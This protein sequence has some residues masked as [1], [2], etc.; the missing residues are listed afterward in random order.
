MGWR[1]IVDLALCIQEH[2]PPGAGRGDLAIV[3]GL[4]F[5]AL[6][7][8]D[9]HEAAPSD[10]AGSPM[11]DARR[12]GC[13]DRGIDCAASLVEYGAADLGGCKSVI[14]QAA[15]S[16]L[17]RLQFGQPIAYFE[18]IRTASPSRIEAIDMGR[19]ALHNEGS[20]VLR[21]RLDGKVALDFD[22]ARRLFT[23]ICVLHI[24]G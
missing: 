12:Q 6:G 19:R 15:R 17:D 13:G 16:A 9:H 5:T 23:L 3:Q 18:A 11:D 21:E 8:V 24:K 4:G 2:V 14:D 10:A 1:F 22:T 7:I 20:E